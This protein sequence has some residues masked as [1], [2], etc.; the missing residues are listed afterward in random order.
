MEEKEQ[1]QLEWTL[2][3]SFSGLQSLPHSL[4]RKLRK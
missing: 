1:S 3:E 4:N 2:R